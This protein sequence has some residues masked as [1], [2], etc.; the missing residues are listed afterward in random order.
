MKILP[1]LAL[2]CGIGVVVL[3]VAGFLFLKGV[4]RFFS[5]T[6]FTTGPAQGAQSIP[7]GY[8]IE[9]DQ[10]FWTRNSNF[11]GNWVPGRTALEGVDA[12][13]FTPVERNKEKDPDASSPNY[14]RDA[15][16]VYYEAKVMPGADPATFKDLGWPMAA[17]AVQVYYEG[18]AIVGAD[19]VTFMAVEG[20]VSRYRDKNHVYARDKV[21]EGADPATYV[22]VGDGRLGRDKNDYYVR[23]NDD[24]DNGEFALHIRDMASFKLLIPAVPPQRNSPWEDLWAF[25]WAR[26]N[27]CFYVGDKVITIADPATFQ[28]L[29]QGYAMDAKQVYYLHRVVAGA[30]P[31]TFQF[32]SP[33][34]DA[35]WEKTFAR[36]GKDAQRV[37]HHEKV[38]DGADAATFTVVDEREFK[39]KS[40][41]YNQGF[42][43]RKE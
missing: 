41:R 25:I 28:N 13:T 39:D 42:R 37:Y 6:T 35:G 38:L 14:G 7:D 9:G 15:K 10:V 29:G 18:R 23:N 8:Q 4:A 19:P 30:D 21:I 12:K 26:D 32:V 24:Y 11:F 17:D 43:D 1:K 36:Y 20:G 34:H 31:Q 2:G 3:V 5:G 33:N 16:H 27:Q 22:P 40:Y